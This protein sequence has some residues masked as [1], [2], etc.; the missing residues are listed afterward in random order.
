MSLI[1]LLI[2]YR[3]WRIVKELLAL[4]CVEIPAQCKI[5][6]DFQ[7]AHRGFSTVIHPNTIIGD[8]VKI[9]HQVTIGRA[10]SYLPGEKSAMKEIVIE[11]DAIIFPGAKILGG[12]GTTK[13]G[14]GTIIAANAVLTK[15]TGEYEIWA[16]IPARKIAE[17]TDIG[18]HASKFA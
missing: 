1:D 15:S 6:S 7:L 11:D 18:P 3:R 13:V 10:D 17:R 14:R 12:P 2:R 5:G 16:G 4:W 9:F 8:R